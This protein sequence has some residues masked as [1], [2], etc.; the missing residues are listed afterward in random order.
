MRRA[1]R[2]LGT[3]GVAAVE[4]AITAPF[5]VLLALGCADLMTALRAQ[6]RIETV[7]VQLG[8][9]VSQCIRITTPGDTGNFFLHGQL[10]AGSIGRVTGNL[11]A[12]GAIVI[13]A[14]RNVGGV[15]RVAW[16]IR[17]GAA[18]PTYNSTVAVDDR[19]GNDTSRMPNRPATIG[20]NFVVPAN[21]TL[22]VT[23]V[24]LDRSALILRGQAAGL[25]IPQTLRANTLFLSRAPDAVAIQSAPASS[26]QADCTA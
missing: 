2:R 17:D 10:M 8:Q 15:N 24:F 22:F 4:F 21:E 20:N 16:Q 12:Q 1:D 5:L 14:V 9:I 19:G 7:A 26:T 6:M 3:R 25:V 13:T 18:S 11:D 23:E